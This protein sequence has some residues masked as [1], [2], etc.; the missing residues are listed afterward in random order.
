MNRLRWSLA[1]LAIFFSWATIVRADDCGRAELD[2][3]ARAKQ[4][5]VVADEVGALRDLGAS[6]LAG[7][8]GCPRSSRL[9]YLAARAAEVL[10]THEGRV[11]FPE[12]GDTKKLS[13][14][15]A[16][17]APESAEIATIVARSEGSVES[18]RRAVNLDPNYLPARRALALALA[19]TGK[20]DDALRLLTG[21][22]QLDRLARAQILNIAGRFREAAPLSREALK[23]YAASIPADAEPTLASDFRREANEALGVALIGEGRKADAIGPLRAAADEGSDRAAKLLHEL[24]QVP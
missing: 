10:E 6:A 19:K 16:A 4:L 11:A 24:R 15:A 9:W 5:F 23:S 14:E 21:A 7:V 18:A 17:H 13:L 1:A 8:Q 12:R 3:D 22:G 20:T 2:L